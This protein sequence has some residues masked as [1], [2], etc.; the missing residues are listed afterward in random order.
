VETLELDIA[1]EARAEFA[2]YPLAGAVVDVAGTEI[3]EEEQA[4][5]EAEKG[6]QEVRPE[7]KLWMIG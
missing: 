4:D 3:Y 7:T 5:A 2:D 1:V 6:A